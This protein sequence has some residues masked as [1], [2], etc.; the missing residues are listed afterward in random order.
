M[1]IRNNAFGPSAGIEKDLNAEGAGC[2]WEN[3]SATG[4]IITYGGCQNGWSYA[5]NLS[6]GTGKCATSDAMITSLPYMNM[7]SLDYHLSAGSTAERF[8]PGSMCP[9]KDIDG[10]PRSTPCAAGADER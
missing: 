3:V 1:K 2:R 9:T 10:Q 8:V 6:M 5:N 7:G 4:N